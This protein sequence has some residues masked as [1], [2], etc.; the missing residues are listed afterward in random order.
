MCRSPGRWSYFSPTCS[1]SSRPRGFEGQV[2]CR[3]PFLCNPFEPGHRPRTDSRGMYATSINVRHSVGGSVGCRG[4]SAIEW[5]D[6]RTAGHERRKWSERKPDDNGD[7]M[8]SVRRNS[9]SRGS[10]AAGSA[11]SGSSSRTGA[12][13]GG[14]EFILTNV[15]SSVSSMP[16]SSNAGGSRTGSATGSPSSTGS[17]GSAGAAAGNP[18]AGGTSSRS[19]SE[20]GVSTSSGAE[21]PRSSEA[22]GARPS[23]GA[24]APL[25][26]PDPRPLAAQP[27][28]EAQR[29]PPPAARPASA[30]PVDAQNVWRHAPSPSDV[31]P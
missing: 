13:G 24:A 4:F 18:P 1:K 6:T 20:A 22:A 2:E 26:V 30:A 3:R 19:G 16:G 15:S 5:T 8:P 10:T 21:C 14:A 12:S 31:H 9:E 25:Q 28:P 27:R 7:W 11:G 17:T 29:A 23:A